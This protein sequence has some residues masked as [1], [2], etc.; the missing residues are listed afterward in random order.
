MKPEIYYPYNSEM[1][2]K[3]PTFIGNTRHV[4]VWRHWPNSFMVGFG[5][6]PLLH[7]YNMP[8]TANKDE[9]NNGDEKTTVGLVRIST[10]YFTFRPCTLPM[11]TSYLDDIVSEACLQHT[12]DGRLIQ[13]FHHRQVVLLLG[14]TTE[15]SRDTR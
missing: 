13:V 1:C 2:T 7:L 9:E 15:V 6:P 8:R 4:V 11:N 10:D 14:R 12:Q 5:K 3:Y